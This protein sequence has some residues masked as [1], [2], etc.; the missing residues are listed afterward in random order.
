MKGDGEGGDWKGMVKKGRGELGEMGWGQ[1]EMG[2]GFGMGRGGFRGAGRR[3]VE[4]R[5]GQE[6]RV[7]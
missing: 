1:V 7:R 5:R 4:I 6:G 3:R 2:R